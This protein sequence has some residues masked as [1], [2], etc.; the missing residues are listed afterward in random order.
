VLS[1]VKLKDTLGNLLFSTTK[2]FNPLGKEKVSGFLMLIVGAGPGLGW[3]LS[4]ACIV[5]VKNKLDN[6]IIVFFM[7]L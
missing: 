3:V 2:T 6:T 7:I 5:K 1:I 4:C